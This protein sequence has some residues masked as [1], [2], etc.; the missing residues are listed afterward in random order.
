METDVE[1]KKRR[2]EEYEQLRI[3]F[4]NFIE[5][6]ELREKH[7]NSVVKSKDLEYQLCEARLEQQ[8]QLLDKET[9]KS[10]SLL[11]QLQNHNK[12]EAELRIQL[13]TYVDKFKQ[14]ETRKKL[15]EGGVSGRR[16]KDE[17]FEK[18]LWI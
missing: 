5:Q 16:H 3:K 9:V 15:E 6:Y 17:R 8:T 7:Y 18:L 4:K 11:K 10:E 12:N 1:E 14:V 2:A 13:T